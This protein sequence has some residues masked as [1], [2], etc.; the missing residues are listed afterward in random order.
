MV[1]SDDHGEADPV[2]AG[3]VGAALAGAGGAPV[4]P[5]GYSVQLTG[6][7]IVARRQVSA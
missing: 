4:T 1:L 6:N 3:A 7:V 2:A 5:A